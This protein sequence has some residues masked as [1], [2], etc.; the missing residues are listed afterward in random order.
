[1][2]SWGAAEGALRPCER[3]LRF[4]C[5]DSRFASALDA[6]ATFSPSALAAAAS[7]AATAARAALA[8]AAVFAAAR[9][10]TFSAWIGLGLN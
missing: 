3:T 9:S 2:P 5:A 7:F 4:M 1:M 8:A 10:A 6:A